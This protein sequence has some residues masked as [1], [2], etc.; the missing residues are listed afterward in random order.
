MHTVKQRANKMCIPHRFVLVTLLS[1]NKV[2]EVG[3]WK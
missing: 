2:E 3:S 1:E